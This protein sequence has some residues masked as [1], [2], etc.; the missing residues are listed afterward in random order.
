[1]NRLWK[2]RIWN[3]S[4]AAGSW[5]KEVSKVFVSGLVVLQIRDRLEMRRQAAQKTEN[6]EVSEYV[7]GLEDGTDQ[8]DGEDDLHNGSTQPSDGNDE[9]YD[10]G[11]Y[12]NNRLFNEQDEDSFAF[13]RG[14]NTVT[15][16]KK[17]RTESG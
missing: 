13:H 7:S 15:G 10:A 11:H 5:L 3:F 4:K 9:Q 16:D 12:I 17:K 6:E 1:M 2:R 14:E 8:R